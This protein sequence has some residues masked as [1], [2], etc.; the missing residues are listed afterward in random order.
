MSVS[1]CV[2]AESLALRGRYC[3]DLNSEVNVQVGPIY[4]CQLRKFQVR[5]NAEIQLFSKW[6]KQL[7]TFT[8]VVFAFET[9]LYFHSTMFHREMVCFLLHYIYLSAV[10]TF[11]VKIVYKTYNEVLH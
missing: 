5:Y 2:V 4:K 9:T 11:Q 3:V 6:W 10:V 1:D 8:Y 7:S